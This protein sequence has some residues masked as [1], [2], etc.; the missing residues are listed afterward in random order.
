MPVNALRQQL[1]AEIASEDPLNGDLLVRII[2]LPFVG[3]DEQDE[4]CSWKV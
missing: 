2:D 4:V 1:E 3:Q